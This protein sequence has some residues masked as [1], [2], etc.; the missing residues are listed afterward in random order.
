MTQAC[1]NGH[2]PVSAAGAD[3]ACRLKLA[4]SRFTQGSGSVVSMEA[5]EFPGKLVA[6]HAVPIDYWG[7]ADLCTF[8]VYLRESAS[9]LPTSRVR[10]TN[11]TRFAIT[12]GAF[13]YLVSP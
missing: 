13:C 10:H 7:V 3:R 11:C 6:L 1:A 12:G 4:L 5:D 9:C 8:T 2:R